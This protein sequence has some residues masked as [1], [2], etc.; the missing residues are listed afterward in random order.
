[1]NETIERYHRH[2]KDTKTGN[3]SVEENM[4]VLSFFYAFDHIIKPVRFMHPHF[5]SSG[6]CNYSVD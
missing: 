3:K 5:V 1:M 6:L 4:Q 2:T